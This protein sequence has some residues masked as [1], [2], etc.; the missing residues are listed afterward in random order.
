[1]GTF[2][3][4]RTFTLRAPATRVHEAVTRPETWLA[5]NSLLRELRLVRRASGPDGLGA[6]YRAVLGVSP[7]YAIVWELETVR[8]TPGRL[9]EWR[10]SGDIEGVGL[11]ELRE[12]GELTRVV[13]TWR[14]RPTQAWMG[15]ISPLTRGL[16]AR[17]Y[18]HVMHAGVRALAA[19]LDI[20][21]VPDQ[22][23]IAPGRA[24]RRVADLVATGRPVRQ[25]YRQHA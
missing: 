25:R 14:V 16:V 7:G 2:E 9:V 6:R 21:V 1:M 12:E 10:A 15:L 3:S 24:R 19:H 5:G 11:W 17:E 18:D 13:N 23:G 4:V 20:A 8:S 22:T